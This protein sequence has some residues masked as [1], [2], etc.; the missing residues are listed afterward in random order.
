MPLIPT[1]QAARSAARDLRRLSSW[2]VVVMGRT[3][4]LGSEVCPK[5]N[6]CV[7]HSPTKRA[8][9]GPKVSWLCHAGRSRGG[10][11]AALTTIVG[12]SGVDLHQGDGGVRD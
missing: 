2:L 8:G 5:S 12:I 6:V 7:V 4:P 10:R 11:V 1:G 9:G 3:I